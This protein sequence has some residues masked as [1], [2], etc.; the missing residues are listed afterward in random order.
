MLVFEQMLVFISVKR[1]NDLMGSNCQGN[2][3][4]GLK[5]NH[6]TIIIITS[7]SLSNGGLYHLVG[8]E[9]SLIFNRIKFI[10]IITDMISD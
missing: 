2:A 9:V 1:D 4:L 3:G 7:Y 6:M 8:M 10:L 5:T